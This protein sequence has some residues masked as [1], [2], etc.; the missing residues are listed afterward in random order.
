[1][2]EVALGRPASDVTAAAAASANL[3]GT[4]LIPDANN[5]VVLPDGASLDD[6][7]VR[8]RDLVI[9]LDDGRVF[10]IPDGAVFVPQIVAQGVTVPPL[11]LAALLIGQEPE[12]A[13]GP[14]RSSGGNFADPV[15][16]IQDAYDLGD[17]LP[18]T[19]LAFPDPRQREI[20]PPVDSEPEVIIITTDNPAGAVDATASVDEAGLPEREGDGEDDAEPEG[21]TAAATS[22]TTTG[23]IQINSPDGIGSLTIGGDPVDLDGVTVI[24]TDRGVL[25][26]TG[27]GTASFTYSYTLTDNTAGEGTTDPFTVVVTDTDGDTATGTLTIKIIDDEPI[28]RNDTDTVAAG[29]FGP[30]T[31]NVLS[32]A[33]TTSGAAGADTKGA[34]D[35]K[36]TSIASNNVPA[37]SDTG[38]DEGGQLEV[39]GQYGTLRIDANGEY[40][41]TRDV[42]TPGGVA[43]VFTY[44]L[45]DGD[46]DT[47]DATLTIRI[48]D[49]PAVITFVPEIGEGTT[50]LESFLPPRGS[51]TQGSQFDGD[52]DVTSSTITFNSPDG[53]SSVSIGGTTITPGALPQTV[54]SNATGILVITGYS[55]NP[56]TGQGSIS[57]T[58]T[59]LDNTLNTDGSTVSFPITVADLDDD[60]AS[61]T[62]DIKIV[63]DA[64]T[65]RDDSG[66]QEVEDQPITVDV[67]ANDTKGADGVNL[68]TSVAVVAGSLTGEGTLVYNN[69]GTFTYT[70]V[71]G[72]EGDENGQ[73]TFQYTIT[74]GDG[75]PSTATVT[76]E[77]LPDS[78]PSIRVIGENVVLEAGLPARDDELEGSNE[79]ADSETTSGTLAI[80]TGNDTVKTLI[81][82]GE[83]VT[84]GGMVAGDH[85]ILTVTLNAGVYSYSYALTDNTSGDATSETFA[86]TVTDSDDDVANTDLIIEIRDDEPAAEMDTDIV[87][88]GSLGPATGNVITDNAAGDLGDLDDGQDTP[89]A[90]GVI[91]NAI[92]SDNEPGNTATYDELTKTYTIAGEYGTL[93][94]E[95]DGDYSYLRNAGTPGSVED[96]FTYSLVDG[97]GDPATA[98]LK[99]F[100]DDN[101][102]VTGENVTALLDDDALGGNPGGDGD[103]DPDTGALSGTLAGSG[104]DGALTW[105][106]LT[107]SNPSGFTYVPAGDDLQVWQGTTKVLTITLDPANG[108]YT[109]TQN[110]PID[111]ALAGTEDNQPFTID[112]QVEDTDGDQAFGVLTI[113]VDDDSPEASDDTDAVTEDGPLSASGNVLSGAGSDSNAAGKDE[114]GADGPATGGAVTAVTGGTVGTAFTT[115]HGSLVLNANG[116]YTYTL[117]NADPAV[118]A[119]DT[120]ETLEESFTYTITDHDGDTTTAVLLITINGAND[121]PVAV[122]DT[123][124]TIEDAAAA[125]T[126]NVLQTLAHP[127]APAGSFSD[128]ADTDSDVE[129]LSVGNPGVYVGTHGT[130]TLSA[131]GTYSYV[132]N[133]A[134]PLV[135]GLDTGETLTDTFAYTASDGTTSTPSAL[136]IT[137]FGANDAPVAVADTNWTIEDAAAPITGNV[138]QTLTHPGAPAGSFSDQADTDADVEPLSVGNPGVYVGTYGTLTLSANG[139]YSYVLNNANPLVQGLDTGETLTDTFAY[140][141]SDGTT[142]TPSTLTITIFGT[143]DAPVAVADTNW[144]IEDAAAP[145]TGN[146]L[147]TLAHPG[148]PAGSFSDQADTDSDVEPLSVGNPGVYVGTYGTLTLSANGTYSYVLNNANPLVQGLD[149]GETLTDTFAYTASDGTTSTPSTLTITIFGTN[150]APVAVA[151][152]NWTIEDAAAPITGNVLQTLAH[153]G[154]PAG[155]FS[156]QADT[157]SDVEPLSVGNPGVYVGTYGTLTLSANGTYSYVLNNANPLVQGLDTGETLTD[158]FAYTASDGTTSTPSTLTITIFGTNDAPVAV[159]DTNWTIEDAAA[160]ITG[161]VLQTLAHPGAPAGSFSDQADTDSRCRTAQRRQPRG[162]CR[163]LRHAHPQRQRHLQLRAQQRQPAG[164]GPRYRRDADRYVRLHR[165]RRHHIDALNAD[166]HHLWHQRRPGGQPR[167]GRGLRRGPRRRQ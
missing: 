68:A 112:Y 21:S 155:S 2:G 143:N 20:F 5:T 1:M 108:A 140:T 125:I 91:L 104:G 4:P 57:Y 144:T 106:F 43:D 6:I 154:A 129:P 22:E 93:K 66:S 157:D 33:G 64:P 47:S 167:R 156:D 141:A 42:G 54:V 46:G 95:A 109:V 82:G 118:Q 94:I 134:N 3:G 84:A 71:P 153:P 78:T 53:V 110:A 41:Y 162:L 16:P 120:G 90:D 135:Q 166:D 49:A 97:D 124:W 28:A 48:A 14:V 12:P 69:D 62:L 34:D 114:L 122:A 55:Y 7:A 87:P 70:P 15:N 152:T 161:N 9:A 35:A 150:D 158:T 45:T 133:N 19:E 119:L 131:N 128:Q 85:G 107:T 116:S 99:I 52:G 146:V 75:D 63:D 17:L 56:V 76:I 10:I 159:A 101:T 24:T 151:D 38:F 65:A 113:D 29:T 123:N 18:Y 139:T 58:Y 86:V 77:L 111:H 132:L 13:A 160:P 103:R 130:L 23:T 44:R 148:A 83:D 61:A 100:I 98:K 51:E 30:E 36:L 115:A 39:K 137:I 92:A 117:N 127:G 145:I 138:L 136:T 60:S 73:V 26:I 96:T 164:P 165:K 50:V 59:L 27:N 142:S 149:T 11:N 32:G 40:T 126:G 163:H 37:N 79:A 74:D 81:I 102:P 121:A 8:G 89:G 67:I 147:Q 31:G 72:E 105:S 80:E 88:G 25:T